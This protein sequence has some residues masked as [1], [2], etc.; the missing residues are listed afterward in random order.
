MSGLDLRRIERDLRARVKDW[1]GLLSRQVPVARQIVVKL[2]D[3]QRLVFTPR[4]DRSY[5]F[6]GRVSVGRLLE[7]IV[8]PSVWRPQGESH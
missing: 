7:G 6:T 1:R 3:G 4:E 5:R 2:V 8:L